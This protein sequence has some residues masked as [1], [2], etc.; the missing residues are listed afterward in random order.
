MRSAS[1]KSAG[2]ASIAVESE[3]EIILDITENAYIVY[4]SDGGVRL[5]S[6]RLRHLLDL[7]DGE[8]G[9][10]RDFSSVARVVVLRLAN[11]HLPLRPPWLLWQPGNG[12]A[13]EQLEMAEP[14][15]ILERIARPVIGDSGRTTGWVERYRDYTYDRDLPARLLQTDKLAALG[16]MVSG[17]AHELNNPLTTIMGYG[18]LLLERQLDS[19][20]LAEAHRICQEAD[21]AARVVRSLLMLARESKLE[22]T[23][24]HLNEIVE[25]TLRLCSYDLQRSGITV[26]LDLDPGLPP[27]LANPVQLQQVVLNLVVNGRQAIVESARPG[28]IVLR[29]RHASGRIFLHV[30]DN[31]PGIPSELQERIFDPFFTTKPVGVGT[32]LGL[33]I[34]SGILRQHGGEIQVASVPGAGASFTASFPVTTGAG[35]SQ[36]PKPGEND[37]APSSRILVAEDEPGVAQLILDVLSAEGHKVDLAADGVEA[38]HR[39]K[40]REYDLVICD[41]RMRNLDGPQLFRSLGN[42]N[43]NGHVGDRFLL[44]TSDPALLSSSEFLRETRPACLTKPFLPPELKSSVTALLL[45]RKNGAHPAPSGG[46]KA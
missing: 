30:E 34:V 21:R 3:L 27:T 32:G 6:K 18:H 28:R 7:D 25:R 39:V 26:E 20:A 22:R 46:E 23:V 4:D 31:G 11:R 12:A 43:G 2:V 14:G 17:I 35:E 19:K 40:S 36:H 16:Q 13:R 41:W 15:R 8:W 5:A 24:V 33:S 37:R 45:K 10:L 9:A 44:I 29:T 38:L 1:T 42:G